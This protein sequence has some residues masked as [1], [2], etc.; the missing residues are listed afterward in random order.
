M[1]GTDASA[2]AIGT[3]LY[4][5]TGSARWL[6]LS[7]LLTVGASALLAPLG[8]RVGDRVDR[9]R[10]MLGA[11]IAACG[12]FVALALVHTPVALLG[13]G[14]LAA[15]IGTIFGPASGAA[16]A[17]IAGEQHLAWAN[18]RLAAAANVG[19]TAGR[20][21]GGA[22]VAVVGTGGVFLL[23]AVS[24]LVSASL[25][26]SVRRAFS[27]PLTQPARDEAPPLPPG[28]G[29]LRHLLG[30]PVLRPVLAA[31][32][33]STFATAFSMTAEIP[34]VFSLG[35][36]PAGVGALTACWGLGMIAGSW[37]AGW[38]LHKGNEA[39]GLFLG[40]LAMAAGVGLMAACPSLAPML[41][42][43]LLGGA[44]GGLT[45]V[46]AQSLILRNV[47]DSLRGRT[48]G[49]IESARNVAFGFGVLGAGVFVDLLGP[50]PVYAC[51]GMAMAVATLPVA[52]LIMRLGGPRRLTPAPA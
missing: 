41:A 26:A 8:G 48:L 44:G 35:A 29:G 9:R 46:A 15:T 6:S 32:C 18:G 16:V 49:A 21:L 34:L 33:L 5:Q 1:A 38:A 20:M 4:T 31:A 12:V 23:D 2:V 17:H 3:A 28:A 39:T 25:I 11:E 40:R 47:P 36:G 10:L 43:Y 19:K 30:H 24:F 45:G 27:E 7:L 14:L 22:A 37:Y 13:L 42:C 52:A 51:V 50:R